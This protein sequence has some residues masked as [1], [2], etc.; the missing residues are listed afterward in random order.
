MRSCAR[1]AF[2]ETQEHHAKNAFLSGPCSGHAPVHARA[3]TRQQNQR[4]VL[5][6]RLPRRHR[7]ARRNLIVKAAV[8]QLR[9]SEEHTSEI[10]S[11]MR[12]SYAV[13]CL[14]T[15]KE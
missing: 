7:S 14:K 10:Q 4:A 2:E 13:F 8:A 15:N 11:L 12:I 1:P 9:R 6:D 5:V 3:C